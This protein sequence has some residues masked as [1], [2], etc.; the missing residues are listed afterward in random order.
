M[1]VL[2]L[3]SGGDTGGAKT[4]I[5]FLLR[6]LQ[7]KLETKIV[8]FTKESFY[9]DV[10]KAGINIEVL[11]QE[12][13]YDMSIV[14][15]LKKKVDKEGYDIIHCHGARAN[16]IGVLLKR[17]INLPFITTI[18]SDYELDFKDNFYKKIIFTK[19]NTL[20]LKKFDYYIAISNNFRNMLISRGFKEEKIFTIYNGIDMDN[21]IFFMPKNEFLNRY[22]IDGKGKTIFGI[23]GRL[24]LVKGHET[25]IEAANLVLKDRKDVLFLIAGTGNDEVRLKEMVKELGLEENIYFLDFVEDQYSFFNAIDVNILTSLSESFP[26][27]ILE[28]AKLKKPVI[29]TKV[30]GIGDLL[31]DGYNGYLIEVG[32]VEELVQYILLFLENKPS[33]KVMGDNLYRTVNE[34][35][36]SKKMGQEHFNIYKKIVETR[37]NSHENNK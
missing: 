19:I 29:S 37:R 11:E 33:M 3:I 10:K 16:F 22:G 4:H 25:F 21:E 24:D 34:K 17:K 36:S 7:E 13:R 23:I 15:K 12:K 14:S 18:H 26:Y 9:Y 20:A 5:I 1:K 2:H 31:K 6:A 28:G 35:F 32:A 8:C 30:G 27:V